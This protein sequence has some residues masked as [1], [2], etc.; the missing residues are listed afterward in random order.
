[1]T[2][3]TG[4][5]FASWIAHDDDDDA[6]RVEGT[7]RGTDTR[8]RRRDESRVVFAVKFH[9][10]NWPRQTDSRNNRLPFA[11]YALRLLLPSRLCVAFFVS[12]RMGRRRSLPRRAAI[13]RVRTQR[14]NLHYELR[15]LFQQA[16]WGEWPAS[17]RYFVLRNKDAAIDL[18]TMW[19]K[20]NR[21]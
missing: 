11:T 16:K 5:L 14:E 7:A 3:S 18:P 21:F 4:L 10:L 9:E 17:L 12:C 19:E 8:W 6:L 1:M 15:N 13:D 20:V 2:P